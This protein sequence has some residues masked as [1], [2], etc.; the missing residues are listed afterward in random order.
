MHL[1]NE[2]LV[3]FWTVWEKLCALPLP[4]AHP[5][6]YVDRNHITVYFQGTYFAVRP[7]IFLY[8]DSSSADFACFLG[9]LDGKIAS[10]QQTCDQP[11]RENPS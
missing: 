7:A 3:E 1:T 11:A 6:L 2:Q 8:E 4:E 5:T 10:L 9:V